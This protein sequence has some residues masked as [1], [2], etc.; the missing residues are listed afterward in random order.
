[1]SN[2]QEAWSR[3][4]NKALREARGITLDA[5]EEK[6]KHNTMSS[7]IRDSVNKKRSRVVEQGDQGKAE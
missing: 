7:L 6:P 3:R 5:S 1:M 4:F 2:E